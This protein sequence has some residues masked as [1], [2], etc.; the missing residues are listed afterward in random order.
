MVKQALIN[1]LIIDNCQKLSIE[2]KGKVV[3]QLKEEYDL[4]YR[5]L[6]NL[7]NIPHSTL[8]DWVTGRQ[9]NKSGSL[10]VSITQLI[11]HFKIYEPKNLI[12]WNNLIQ[13]SKVL[14]D[15][16]KKDSPKSKLDKTLEWD[17]E[18]D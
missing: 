16:I 10:H 2:E 17:N 14:E 3:K 5:A 13:L 4:S 11:K 9:N 8:L 6:E 7:T 18:T 15:R 12:E 1:S